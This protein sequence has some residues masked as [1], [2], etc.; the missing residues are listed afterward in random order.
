MGSQNSIRSLCALNL[1]QLFLKWV[2]IS[3]RVFFFSFFFFFFFWV[4]V[5]PA[6]AAF[7]SLKASE[8]R[9][10]I[11]ITGVRILL[12]VGSVL[13][14]VLQTEVACTTVENSQHRM[15]HNCTYFLVVVFPDREEVKYVHVMKSQSCLRAS[16]GNLHVTIAPVVLYT[17]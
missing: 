4:T 14:H 5:L 13:S 17:V 1:L 7:N 15:L 3:V 12:Q 10:C 8:K 11:I 2:E 9:F 6:F 16:R